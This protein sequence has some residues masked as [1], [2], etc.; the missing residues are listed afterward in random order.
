[1]NGAQAE[2]RCTTHAGVVVV[3][4]IG[5]GATAAFVI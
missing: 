4:K 1:M 3:E 2:N 5:E